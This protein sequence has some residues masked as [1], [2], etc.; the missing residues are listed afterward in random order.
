MRS[1]RIHQTDVVL[2][3]LPHLSCKVDVAF[4]AEDALYR[5]QLGFVEDIFQ[6]APGFREFRIIPDAG[7]WVQ[8]EDPER[9]NFELVQLLV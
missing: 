9:F 4:G 1:R 2:R 8:F 7:H 3:A 6:I 5:S